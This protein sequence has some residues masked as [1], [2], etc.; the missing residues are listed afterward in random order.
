MIANWNCLI[1]DYLDNIALC[2]IW[3]FI[4]SLDSIFFPLVHA[5]SMN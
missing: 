4:D 2:K 5:Q 3:A 1:M